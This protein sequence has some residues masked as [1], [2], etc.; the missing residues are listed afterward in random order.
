M[1]GPSREIGA[2][3]IQLSLNAMLAH[4]FLGIVYLATVLIVVAQSR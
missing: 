2:R 4:V 1:A 3:N